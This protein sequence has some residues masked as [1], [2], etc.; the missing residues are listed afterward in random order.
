M[1]INFSSHFI[2]I[3]HFSKNSS[4]PPL[5]FS[6]SL[7]SPPP[8]LFARISSSSEIG[9]KVKK[10]FQYRNNPHEKYRDDPLFVSGSIGR[11][12]LPAHFSRATRSASSCA[13]VFERVTSHTPTKT[14]IAANPFVGPNVSNPIATVNSTATIG[15]T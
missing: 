7:F 5:R 8:S 11:T 4:F 2:L 9:G 1:R 6:L 12:L 3:S 15:C 13:R 10:S 14:H